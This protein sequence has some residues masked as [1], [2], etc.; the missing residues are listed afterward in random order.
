MK[1]YFLFSLLIFTMCKSRSGESSYFDGRYKGEHGKSK[2][3]ADLEEDGNRLTGQLIIDGKKASLNG[4]IKETSSTGTLKDRESGEVFD[5]DLELDNDKLTFRLSSRD[6]ERKKVKLILYRE[7]DR[8]S[9]EDR[10]PRGKA[11]KKSKAMERN[12]DLVG[13]WKNSEVLGSGEMSFATEYFM[14]LNE[15]GTMS[16]WT[17]QSAGSGMSMDSDE[18]NA[19]RGEWYTD[20]DKLYFVDPATRQEDYTLYE[21]SN[22]G[23]LLHNG[24]REK[25]VYRRVR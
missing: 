24:G 11:K 12:S 21:V 3:T 7:D 19:S 16:A 9:S 25:K 1:K 17:G 20:G 10:E 15:D 8:P 4:K 13:L 5:Y 23:L 18:A 14:E 2:L 6:D 22:S